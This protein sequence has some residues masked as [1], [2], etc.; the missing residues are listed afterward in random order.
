M[1]PVRL[2]L[3][4][5]QLGDH[6]ELL[7]A[8]VGGNGWGWTVMN[9][10]DG[11]DA[12]HRFKDTA[13]QA[14]NLASI[15]LQSEDFDLREFNPNDIEAAFGAPGFVWVRGG[16]VFTLRMAMARSGFDRLIVDR[17]EADALVYAG[18]SAG[19]CV[20]APS[21]SGLELCDSMEDCRDTYGDVRFDGL[22]LLDRPVVPHLHSP[23][24]P[25]TQLLS[26]VAARYD[27]D[28]ERYWGLRD[29]EALVVTG[30]NPRIHT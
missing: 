17:L 6:P 23:H 22:A 25:E 30:G 7:R 9:A 26:D 18:F 24:H 13:K 21:L 27:A 14:R 11:A 8:M 10:L 3:S 16:N 19:A 5:Y 2:Y 4:S 15:G 28:G 12:D 29:G 1:V 20:L